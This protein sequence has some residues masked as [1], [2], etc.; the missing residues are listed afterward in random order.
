M[1]IGLQGQLNGIETATVLKEKFG[2]PVIYVTA[3]GDAAAMNRV[4]A[5]NHSATS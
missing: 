4:K 3:H 1:D 2:V 5:T